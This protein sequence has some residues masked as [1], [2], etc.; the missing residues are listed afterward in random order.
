MRKVFKYKVP[1]ADTFDLELPVNAQLLHVHNQNDEIWLWALVDLEVDIVERRRFR[2]AG[3]GHPVAESTLN[4]AGTAHI[5]DGA[6]VFHLFEV[7]HA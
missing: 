4:Y 7:V 6:L 3:T 2:L 1:L 5:H